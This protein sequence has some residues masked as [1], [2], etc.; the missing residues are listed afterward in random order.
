[1]AILNTL[2]S[3][4]YAY[5]HLKLC[6]RFRRFEFARRVETKSRSYF[7]KTY[8]THS[9]RVSSVI[10]VLVFNNGSFLWGFYLNKHD[11]TA[12]ISTLAGAL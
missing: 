7:F 9:V 3:H 11:K 10:A 6:P 2:V 1:M 8:L 5:T 12:I 4:F